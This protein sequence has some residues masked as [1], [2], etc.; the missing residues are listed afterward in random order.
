ML[1]VFLSALLYNKWS[2]MA[3]N[4][5]LFFSNNNFLWNP[6]LSGQLGAAKYKF[7]FIE[8]YKSKEHCDVTWK[9]KLFRSPLVHPIEERK[10]F[11]YSLL[12][13]TWVSWFFRYLSRLHCLNGEGDLRGVTTTTLLYLKHI[14]YILCSKLIFLENWIGQPFL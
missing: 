14:P 13:A 5:F 1:T 7:D 2:I 10:I 6:L 9:S 11:K 3:K 8:L 12:K 4:A